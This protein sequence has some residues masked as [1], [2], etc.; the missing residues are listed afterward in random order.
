MFAFFAEET[1]AC[2]EMNLVNVL[3]VSSLKL[4]GS[5]ISEDVYELLMQVSSNIVALKGVKDQATS[6]LLHAIAKKRAYHGEVGGT[7]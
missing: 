3:S 7:S 1:R 5:A 6:P 2:L 4:K